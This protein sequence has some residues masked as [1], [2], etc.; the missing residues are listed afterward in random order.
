MAASVSLVPAAAEGLRAAYT[1]GKT[2]TY[3]WRVSQLNAMLKITT[4]HEK[5]IVL[6]LN[7]DLG[8]HEHEAFLHEVTTQ[9]R[10]RCV[11]YPIWI[12]CMRF[13]LMML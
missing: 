11:D 2:R 9:F 6:A 13:N 10:L 1:S 5:D 3:E 4:R 8:K 12:T 7:S